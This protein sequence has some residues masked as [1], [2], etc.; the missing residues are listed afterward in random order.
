MSELK[1]GVQYTIVQVVATP[2][3]VVWMFNWLLIILVAI[4]WF[5]AQ[6]NSVATYVAPSPPEPAAN[7]ITL[8]QLVIAGVLSLVLWYAIGFGVHFG[9]AKIA[10]RFVDSLKAYRI[11]TLGG[12]VLSSAIMIIVGFAMQSDVGFTLGVILGSLCGI[13]GLVS[14]GLQ[15]L[16]AKLWNVELV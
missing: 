8:S 15:Q 11:M 1:H 3:L 9:L 4:Y 6:T 13:V 10:D 14:F 16:L 12:M 7:G 5:A 2:G